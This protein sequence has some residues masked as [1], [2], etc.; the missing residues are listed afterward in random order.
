MAKRIQVVEARD[1]IN[2]NGIIGYY[3]SG[4]RIGLFYNDELISVMTF[5][6]MRIT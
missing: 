4:I 2:K 6:Q 5:N 3:Y 1:F